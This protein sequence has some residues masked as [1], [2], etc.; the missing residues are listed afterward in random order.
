L[1]IKR[2]NS[3]VIASKAN[4]REQ[5]ANLHNKEQ[6]T[7]NLLRKGKILPKHLIANVLSI[8]RQCGQML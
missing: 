8:T 1:Y 4:F 3:F 6:K 7:Q 2:A 5:V